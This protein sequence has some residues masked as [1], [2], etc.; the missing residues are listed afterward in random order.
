MKRVIYSAVFL[1]ALFLTTA[2]ASGQSKETR[3]VRNFSKVNFGVSGELFIK[4]GPE[5]HL[6]IEGDKRDIDEIETVV[7]GDRL[8][9]RKDN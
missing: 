6:T 4:I 1:F 8:T 7:S 3:N 9:I 5:F 2:I